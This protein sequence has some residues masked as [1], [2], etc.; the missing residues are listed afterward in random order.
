M[1]THKI[2]LFTLE[3]REMMA[4]VVLDCGLVKSGGAPVRPRPDRRGITR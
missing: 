2:A 1:D 4:R 3:G